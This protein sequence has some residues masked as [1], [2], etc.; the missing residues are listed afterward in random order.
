MERMTHR[1]R[2]DHNPPRGGGDAELASGPSPTAAISNHVVRL[3]SQHIGRGPTKARTIMN[4]DLVCV[5]LHD[6][7]TKG[8]RLLVRD[9]HSDVVLQMRKAHQRV[10]YADLAAGVEQILQRRVLAVMSD[11]HIDPDIAIEAFVLAP[12]P[13][14]APA[15][16]ARHLQ[17]LEALAGG[18]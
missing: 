14:N 16:A 17:R 12:D 7:L 10:M 6:T 5:V 15:A 18:G 1:L 11:N 3:M 8:E 9:G 4:D 2:P 13:E